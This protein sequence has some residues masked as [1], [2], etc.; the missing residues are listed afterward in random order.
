MHKENNKN[1]TIYPVEY[2]LWS[3]TQAL[4]APFADEPW[5]ILLDSA[6]A[7]HPDSRY[8]II[9]RKPERTIRLIDQQLIC[10]PPLPETSNTPPT[11]LFTTIQAALAP[12][13]DMQSNIPFC[14]GAV[15]YFGYNAGQNAGYEKAGVASDIAMPDAAVGIYTHALVIDHQDK[16][17]YIVAPSHMSQTDAEAFWRAEAPTVVPFKRHSEWQ[18]NLTEAEYIERFERFQAYVAA[19]ECHH[20]NLAQRFTAECTGSSWQAYTTLR[21]TNGTPFSGFMNLEEGAVLSLSPERFVRVSETGELQTKPIKGTRPRHA[22]PSKDA[23]LA[24]ELLAS[25]K[26]RNE[27]LLVVQLLT[28]DIRP[29]CVPESIQTPQLLAI[30]SFPAVHHLVSTLVAQL[31]PGHDALDLMRAV[32]PGGSITGHPKQQAI[33]VIAEL[34]PHQRSVYCGS[35]AYF[36]FHGAADSNVTIRTLCHSQ[37]KLHCWAGGGIVSQSVASEEYQETFDKVA[38]ILPYL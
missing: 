5:A 6:N 25:E 16:Q 38:R 9:V 26:E 33:D 20:I 32:M 12:Y 35:L 30:E 29:V 22:V 24:A 36:S 11:D 19:G 13:Q 31:K 27:N 14:G 3:N 10:Q 17:S 4:F 28:D 23:A 15:G 37:D 7:H 8:D 34:E 18:S 2:R 21:E 1:T